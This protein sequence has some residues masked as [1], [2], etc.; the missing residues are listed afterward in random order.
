MHL[1]A[2]YTEHKKLLIKL[3]LVEL[4][5]LCFYIPL[6][7]QKENNVWYFGSGVGLSFNT[8]P[9][10]PLNNGRLLA[11]EGCASVSD[12]NGNLLFY[13]DGFTM[14]NKSHGIMKNGDSLKSCYTSTQGALI[15]KQPGSNSLYYVFSSGCNSTGSPSYNI[16]GFHY[17]VIDITKNGGFGEV[18]QK[19]IP[20]L[21]DTSFEKLVAIKDAL[22]CG[23]WVVTHDTRHGTFYSFH[24]TASGINSIPI[25]SKSGLSSSVNS[26]GNPGYLK[27]SPNG[28]KIATAY[29]Y[30]NRV[31]LF[32]FDKKSGKV[33]NAR[34]LDSTS[35]YVYYGLAFSP[36]NK[37]LYVSAPLTLASSAGSYKSELYQYDVSL[38]STS[39]IK[40][41]R[42]LIY[43][44]HVGSPFSYCALQLGP[45][46]KIYLSQ[47]PYSSLGY[48]LLGVINQPNKPGKLCDYID[49]GV[50]IQKT[51]S[52]RTQFGLPNMVESLNP[53]GFEFNIEDVPICSGKP[54][55]LDANHIA[56]SYLWSTGDTVPQITTTTPGIYTLTASSYCGSYT[57]TIKV[58]AVNSSN[59]L[60]LG[61]DTTYCGL[62]SHKLDGG[63]N[64]KSYLWN[65]GDITS[66]LLVDSPGMYAL[67]IIDSNKCITID[68][69]IIEA[70]KQPKIQAKLDTTDCPFI[71]LSVQT[72]DSLA[73]YTWNT[74]DTGYS[75]KVT[76]PGIYTA[77]LNTSKCT[78]TSSILVDS[79]P[80]PQRLKFDLGSDT[81]LCM[82][83]SYEIKGGENIKGKLLWNTGD[84]TKTITVSTRGVYV[85]T[86]TSK[87][88][89]FSDSVEVLIGEPIKVFLGNDT[90]FCDEF[91]HLLE[92][93]KGGESYLWSTGDTT[94]SILVDNPD[95][96]TVTVSD[97][98][99]CKTGDTINIGQ[100]NT[101]K[102]S[103]QLDSLTCKY[104]TLSI[105]EQ[106][107]MVKYLWST[108][109]TTPTI[110]VTQKGVYSITLSSRFC[111]LTSSLQVE[112]LSQPEVDLGTD[113][114][115][116]EGEPIT[117][118]AGADSDSY[119]WNTKD[120]T[121]EIT[122]FKEGYYK[123]TVERNNCSATDSVWV[124]P[125]C[126]MWYAIP[127]AFTP[128]TDNLNE[129]FYVSGEYIKHIDMK[130][131]TRWGE[132][133]YSGKGKNPTWDGNYK[134]LQSPEGVYIYSISV[135]GYKKGRL[136]KANHRGNITLLR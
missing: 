109:D 3:L 127:N 60:F 7:A 120:T 86:S 77:T 49:S 71:L 33:S 87:C 59:D 15:L 11:S 84:T 2:L 119:L 78:L 94:I 53:Y 68:T 79:I 108:G 30:K 124:G 116:C 75:L 101:P 118:N 91:S 34:L 52:E 81:I 115:I 18:I 132:L 98:N 107:S 10:T 56:G 133:I 65:T 51:G 110:Q 37:Y 100:L 40:A 136:H 69:I 114:S 17:S 46:S 99:S 19:N 93:R 106:D 31:E 6:K 61:N 1:R 131:F 55:V 122:V 83:Q 95:I 85:L 72:P 28:K 103:L 58:T 25:R 8:T 13:T 12:A 128:T 90:A 4:C 16:Y 121:K 57:D 111:S 43:K 64:M 24:V 92:A 39:L 5:A 35:G 88:G 20:L 97:S 96:Y 22:G 104:V 82:G 117:L 105:P 26:G 70:I 9:P 29:Y 38:A 123:V 23:F 89:S 14:F 76:Q 32:D 130:I 48:S 62:F 36:N 126:D 45:D 129:L 73:T 44:K 41:S 42:E 63:N 102:I 80:L 50:V 54:A 21:K 112:K 67:T 125:I 47:N 27:A 113:T 135:I 74:N 66:A 134:L